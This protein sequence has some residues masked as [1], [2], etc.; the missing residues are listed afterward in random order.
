FR[1]R[2]PRWAVAHKYP[3][4]EARTVVAAIDVQVGR[5]GA[6]TPVAKLQPVFVGGVTVTNATLHNEDEAR[7]KDV[8]VGDTVIVRRAGDVIP[9]V[10]GVVPE[11][12]PTPP[13]PPFS[14][15][16]TCPQCGSR[17][18]REE[19]EAIARCAGGLVCPAQVKG[20][21]LHFAGRRAMDIE[22]LG[23]KLVEQLTVSGQVKAPAGLYALTVPALAALERM[24]D[25][26]AENLV[27][28]IAKSRDT[29][30]ARFIFA[31]GVRN[32]GESTA[33]DLAR[34]FGKLDNLM[35]ADAAALEAVPDVGPVVAES[36][37]GFF[38]EPRNRE[39]VRQLR[40]AGVNW[41]EGEAQ[42]GRAGALSGKTL[43]LTG[44]LPSLSRDEA[45]ALIE[46]AG[47][48]VS[49]SVSKKTDYVV[50]GEAAGSKLDKARELNLNVIGEARL[51]ELL[52]TRE[53]FATQE[54][55]KS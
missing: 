17:V 39:A 46:A 8:R 33:R 29:T 50:A 13:P 18:V 10:V 28:A 7:R 51:R 25:K 5:T 19:G 43:V 49:G 47:G 45:K 6:L 3:A 20:A 15:P 4:E 42:A 16:E 54:G 48:K 52:A 53:L 38:A 23:D 12:R 32:V 41:P 35:A 55:T 2:E 37:V 44:T 36:I 26:S 31:L 14:L 9:E 21:L 11:A 27:A 22:G 40:E 30:L 1:S 24:G 34:H